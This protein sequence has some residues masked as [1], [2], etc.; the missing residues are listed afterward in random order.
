MAN[1]Y[2]DKMIAILD[3]LTSMDTR[4]QNIAPQGGYAEDIG[5]GTAT[6][7]TVTHSLGTRDVVVQLRQNA[8]P[9]EYVGADVRAAT[10]TTVT[11]QFLTPPAAGA[12]RILITRAG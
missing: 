4:L 2:I 8:S 10:T 11:V 7:F 5:D 6:L 12:Y 9:W 3:T 1:V